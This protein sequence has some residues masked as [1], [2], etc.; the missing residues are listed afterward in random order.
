MPPKLGLRTARVSRTSQPWIPSGRLIHSLANRLQKSEA[1]SPPV[2]GLI[3]NNRGRPFGGYHAA[4]AMTRR[5]CSTPQNAP[6]GSVFRRGPI[7][8]I[9]VDSIAS[10]RRSSRSGGRVGFP[11]PGLQLRIFPRPNP[12]I[13]E[14][15]NTAR[16]R[17]SRYQRRAV[18][19]REFCIG[20]HRREWSIR[21]V[22]S[23]ALPASASCFRAA[24]QPCTRS[25]C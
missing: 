13:S 5:P 21:S 14:A 16:I 24:S 1:S 11:S 18:N 15:V 6:S 12:R 10:A 9:G 20:N 25:F 19:L 8:H 22:L 2:P 7:Q 23:R 17:A 3:S 4:R